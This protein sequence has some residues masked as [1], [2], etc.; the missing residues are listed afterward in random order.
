VAAIGAFHFM[1]AELGPATEAI[2]RDA[3][4]SEITGDPAMSIWTD[5]AHGATFS[6]FRHQ[7]LRH[8]AELDRGARLYDERMHAG[9]MLMTGFDAGM[10]C[11]FQG[12]RVAW[13]LGETEAARARIDATVAQA[14]KLRH[15]LMLAFSL[16]FQ[17]WIRQHA[18]DP[19]VCSR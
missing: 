17:A 9:F 13:M 10:G 14:R 7:P 1:R 8:M 6:H 5:W 15:P 2:R 3:S 18:R 16:F 11:E 19:R 12:A 4:L